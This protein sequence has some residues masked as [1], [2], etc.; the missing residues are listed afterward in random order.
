MASTIRHNRARGTHQIVDM[1]HIV[2]TLTEN[3][4]NDNQISEHLGMELDEII[5]LKQITG[6]KDAFSNH[7]FRNSLEVFEYYLKNIKS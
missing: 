4:W 3:G 7:K 6:L 5:R 2:L 1:S